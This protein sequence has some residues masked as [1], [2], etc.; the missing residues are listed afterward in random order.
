MSTGTCIA[1]QNLKWLQ[2]FYDRNKPFLWTKIL[3]CY[4]YDRWGFI[5]IISQILTFDYAQE[6]R[7]HQGRRSFL[8]SIMV[9]Q[10]DQKRGRQN[11]QTYWKTKG[12][13]CPGDLLYETE[14]HARIQKY[15]YQNIQLNHLRRTLQN[16]INE[17]TVLQRLPWI[18]K[19]WYKP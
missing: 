1:Q 5:N 18:L 9:L 17:M 13:G 19:D 3:Q 12:K 14:N 4:Q 11:W 10:A 7:R 6:H 16:Q 8:N 2:T 15:Q